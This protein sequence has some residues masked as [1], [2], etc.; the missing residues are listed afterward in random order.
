M[1]IDDLQE[2][3]SRFEITTANGLLDHIH[4]LTH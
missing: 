2:L 4:S 1:N 3:Y